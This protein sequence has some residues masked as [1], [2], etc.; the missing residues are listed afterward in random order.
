MTASTSCPLSDIGPALES[1]CFDGTSATDAIRISSG[2][3]V[4]HSY[5]LSGK[6]FAGD[7]MFSDDGTQLAYVT[8]PVGR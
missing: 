8:I 6:N 1:V 2:G 3:S 5:A 4:I 7:A